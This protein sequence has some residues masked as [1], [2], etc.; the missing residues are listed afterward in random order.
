MITTRELVPHLRRCG[1]RGRRLRE[2]YVYYEANQKREVSV[3]GFSKAAY[4][5][6]TACIALLD[7][8]PF[9]Q[10][11][12]EKQ[13]SLYQSFGSPIVLV[14][15]DDFLQFWHF[16]N[17]K[18][19]CK[20]QKK[21]N[22]L[23]KFFGKYQKAFSPKSISR[24]KIYGPFDEE[25]R[26]LWFFD[27]RL[28]P[29][30]ERQ[31]GQYLSGL[32]ERII[33]RLSKSANINQKSNQGA[34]W[35]TQAAFWLVGARILKDKGVT[36]FETLDIADIELVSSMVRYHY[37]AKTSLDI[38]SKK[39]KEALEQAATEILKPV[40][41]FAHLAI[42][43]LAYVY[44]NTLVT[45]ATRKALGTHATPSW[46]VNYIVWQ[47]VDWI[48]KI[49]QKDRV[50]LEPACG[51]APFLTAGARIL[52]FL[53]GKDQQRH[54]YLKNHLIG[55]EKDLFAE[56]IARLALTLAD[57][58]NKDG[59]NIINTDIYD[60]DILQRTAERATILLCNPPFENFSKEEKQKYNNIETGNKAAEVLARTLPYMPKGSV[61]GVIL[62]QGF[63]DRK[64]LAELRKY[65]LDNFELR[66]ICNLPDNVFTKAGHPATVLLGCKVKSRKRIS[67]LTIPKANLEDF[68]NR[69]QAKETFLSKDQLYKAENYSFKLTELKEIWD[70]CREYPE[71]QEY[72]IIGRGIEYKDFDKSVKKEKFH[73][74]VKG[75]ASFEKLTKGKKPK[76]IDINIVGLPDHFWMSLNE[77]EIQNPR[78]GD[79]CGIPQ[80]L[81]SYLRGGRGVWRIKGLVDLEG[82]PVTNKLIS[83]RP[84]S[85]KGNS[86]SLYV[87]W[88][89][90]NSPFTNAYMFCHCRRQNLEGVLR[91][92]P[93]P[94]EHQDLF[95]LENMVRN[96]FE[97][98]DK[99][100]LRDGIALREKEKQCLLAIDAEV[101]RLYDLP[102]RLEKQLL[103]F[104]AGYQRKGVDFDFKEYYPKGFGSYIPLHIFISEEF[105]NSTVENVKKWVERNR[106]PE[107]IKAFDNAVNAFEGD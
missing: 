18:P 76:K 26:Q 11:E 23:D 13:V 98:Q 45:P 46:L 48:E 50:M 66:T 86:L 67:Y 4:N 82:L 35:L 59:W 94:F 103:D 47:L 71:F 2:N 104:F 40:S 42:D 97:Y 6:G 78:Y 83:I 96:Y 95:K 84:I 93:V 15:R 92:M 38:S 33:N 90:V 27:F 44:E 85:Q 106:T 63:L 56:E 77:D 37:G 107:V 43:S 41:S 29:I 68:M 73:G 28:M 99:F 10:E 58:P 39:K 75:Y 80:I 91:V 79:Q 12:T 69:Y 8:N 57:I 30:I 9:A 55:L 88:A 16:S 34:K 72:A 49:P 87:I 62:P 100:E 3:A 102:P 64:N 1:Y 52:S 54:E 25:S 22:E 53:Y 74:A 7:G 24:A 32:I 21:T 36:D 20:E 5:A 31:E 19:I 14:Y 51:H 60:T 17:G 105:Q 61:F 81:T 65:I 89:L 70:Y 101:L